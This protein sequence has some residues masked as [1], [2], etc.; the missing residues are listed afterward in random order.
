M[1]SPLKSGHHQC[2]QCSF[3][4]K[5][6][7][8]LNLHLSIHDST[9]H[10]CDDHFTTDHDLEIHFKSFH[11][12]RRPSKLVDFES[13]AEDDTSMPAQDSD[14]E[15]ELDKEDSDLDF[16]P[17]SDEEEARC[18][19]DHSLIITM[20]ENLNIQPPT[21]LQLE[22]PRGNLPDTKEFGIPG[23][24][25]LKLIPE[26]ALYLAH[27]KNHDHRRQPLDVQQNVNF[28]HQQEGLAVPLY[29]TMLTFFFFF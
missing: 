1:S 3:T 27:E 17:D 23:P 22:L 16:N 21:L 20:Q 15:E 12:M 14:A 24:K 9:C 25:L 2:S 28:I 10:F 4:T 13:E 26:L 6:L 5:F 7:F 18:Q 8:E 19:K 11:K 29:C